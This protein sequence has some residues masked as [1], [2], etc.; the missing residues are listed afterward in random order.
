MNNTNNPLDNLYASAN[1]QSLQSTRQSIQSANRQSI[2]TSNESIKHSDVQLNPQDN[3]ENLNK[4]VTLFLFLQ[5][6]MKLYHWNTE[7]YPRHKASDEFLEK[8]NNNVDKFVEVYIGRYNIK[9]RINNIEI[10]QDITDTNIV[11][12]L[13]RCRKSFEDF[14]CCITDTGLLNIR[15]EILSDINQTLYLFRLNDKLN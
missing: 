5:N 10:G 7:N 9:P 2:K 11:E 3:N 15:D 12:L 14:S 1:R 8:L 13:T 4:I 6:T